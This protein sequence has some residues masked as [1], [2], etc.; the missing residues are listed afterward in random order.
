MDA[1][2]RASLRGRALS[3]PLGAFNKSIQATGGPHTCHHNHR[4]MAKEWECEGDDTR[5]QSLFRPSDH[6][7]EMTEE[8][9]EKERGKD[10]Y[11]ERD[12]DRKE[13]WDRQIKDK[14]LP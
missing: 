10:I 7:I 4:S 2:T 13:Q 12:G 3:H 6:P 11:G 1:H 9:R 5:R 14:S 8:Q